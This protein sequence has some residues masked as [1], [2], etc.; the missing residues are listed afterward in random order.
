MLKRTL[1]AREKRK[2]LCGNTQLNVWHDSFLQ[3]KENSFR[4]KVARVTHACQICKMSQHLEDLIDQLILKNEFGEAARLQRKII[5]SQKEIMPD[6][7]IHL[8][9]ILLAQNRTG[10]SIKVGI[11]AAYLCV[12][13]AEYEKATFLFQMLLA[14]IK[15][16]SKESVDTQRIISL[17]CEL[18]LCYYVQKDSTAGEKVDELKTTFACFG[19]SNEYNA[20]KNK[21]FDLLRNEATSPLLSLLDYS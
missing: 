5:A 19:E 6:A 7:S 11:E 21:R 12:E 4:I 8:F 1:C 20:L 2:W 9:R 3:P 15:G 14:L 10:E 13:K 16:D 18:C 17:C